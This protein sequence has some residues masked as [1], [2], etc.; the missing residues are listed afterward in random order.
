MGPTLIV[1]LCLTMFANT[2]SIGAFP[3]L[4]P[5]LGSV[6]GLSDWQLG[7][8][9]G[10]FGFARMLAD[11]PVGL[12]ITHHLRWALLGAPLLLAAGVLTLASGGSF[13]VLLLGRA[14]LG[15]AHATGIVAALT[16]VLRYS[17]GWRLGSALNAVEFSAMLGI[18]GGT[19]VL[20]LLPTRFAWNTALLLACAPQLIGILVAPLLFRA[21]PA[22]PAGP[23]APL[24]AR[25][26]TRQDAGEHAG[27]TPRILL[28]FAA[29]GA[30]AVAYSTVEQFAI[31]LR[32]SREFGLDRAGVARLLMLTQLSDIVAL[33]PV[34]VLSDRRGAA[35][36]LVL[37][38]YT[39]ALAT[40]LVGFGGLPL[41]T[42][43]C[44][45]FGLAMA[46]W[47]LP[48]SVLRGETSPDQVAWR[49][50]LYRVIVDA[51]LFLGPFASGL[52][53]TYQVGLLPG[54]CAVALAAVGTLL[55]GRQRV[56]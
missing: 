41:L 53:G 29:G 18:L 15:V 28:A 25:R 51:G 6:V 56:G 30:V 48:L 42:V 37:I 50:A 14:L 10:A 54:A 7:T 16:A 44:G 20:G 38:L 19:V 24:F 34:G 32:G 11:I 22:T 36:V 3:A 31:P 9:A 12:F 8:L 26:A 47:M 52:L 43:G 2:F 49:T 55:L 27:S 46:G 45:L 35:P 13:P 39:M 23:D 33:L 5:E 17:A 40:A 1:L 4:L 21:L